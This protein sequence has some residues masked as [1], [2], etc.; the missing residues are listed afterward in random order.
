MQK[1]Y[2]EKNKIRKFLSSKFL[3]QVTKYIFYWLYVKST[4]N[5]KSS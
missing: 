2:I 4:F 3:N 5:V 1:F